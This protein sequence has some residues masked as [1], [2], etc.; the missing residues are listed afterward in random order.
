M[1]MWLLVPDDDGVDDDDAD[2]G[3]DDTD[4]DEKVNVDDLNKHVQRH[5]TCVVKYMYS[6]N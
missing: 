4:D 3:D 5:N 6:C 1:M 2:S